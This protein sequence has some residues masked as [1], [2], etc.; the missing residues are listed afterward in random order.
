MSMNSDEA[1]RLSGYTN[2]DLKIARLEL[3]RAQALVRYWDATLSSVKGVR[4]HVDMH[5]RSVDA[6]T[7]EIAAVK[8]GK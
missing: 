8:A 5:R 2:G 3:E 4:A 7:D 1:A 6:L